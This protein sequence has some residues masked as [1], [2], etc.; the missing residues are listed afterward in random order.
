MAYTNYKE[1]TRIEAEKHFDQGPINYNLTETLLTM[2]FRP[3][4]LLHMDSLTPLR[5]WSRDRVYFSTYCNGFV[6]VHSVER[7]FYDHEVDH[8]QII[9]DEDR[10]R[11]LESVTLLDQADGVDS[12]EGW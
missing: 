9:L 10:P 2:S 4:E 6:S 11:R 12:P 7:H 5:G 3:Y 1:L 8:V